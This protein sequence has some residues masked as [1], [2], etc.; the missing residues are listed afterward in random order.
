MIN[1][2][3]NKTEYICFATAESN[4]DLVPSTIQFDLKTVKRVEVTCV[5]AILFDSKL[6]FDLHGQS[7]YGRLLHRWFF[8]LKRG[9]KNWGL[10]YR[11]MVNLIKV[12]LPSLLYGGVVIVIVWLGILF[13]QF[14]C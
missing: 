2:D 14:R 6:K 1:C 5:L 8:I 11:V 12:F 13:R 7:E 10:R 4:A 3:S 9:N